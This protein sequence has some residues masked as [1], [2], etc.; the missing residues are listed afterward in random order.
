MNN[1][2]KAVLSPP[3]LTSPLILSLRNQPPTER[4]PTN[5]C[6][7]SFPCS[8][9]IPCSTQPAPNL[10]YTTIRETPTPLPSASPKERR[11]PFQWWPVV[12]CWCLRCQLK[13]PLLV[14]FIQLHPSLAFCCL[15]GLPISIYRFCTQRGLK[16]CTFWMELDFCWNILSVS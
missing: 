3:I 2:G 7:D 10:S 8:V 16:N 1:S 12:C 4:C 6:S 14:F 5:D 11:E 9:L 15:L 13:M